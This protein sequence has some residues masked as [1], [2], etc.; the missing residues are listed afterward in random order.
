MI[1]YQ[2]IIFV[3]TGSKMGFLLGGIEGW[4]NHIFALPYFGLEVFP[5]PAPH[6][7]HH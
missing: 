3:A 2:M 1:I 4:Q 5:I 7:P 6:F